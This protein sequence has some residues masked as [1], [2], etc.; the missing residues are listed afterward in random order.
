MTPTNNKVAYV[1]GPISSVPNFNR[2]AFAEATADLRA[3][4]WKVFSPIEQDALNGF[5]SNLRIA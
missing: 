1:S 3:K 5:R 4:G 2:D